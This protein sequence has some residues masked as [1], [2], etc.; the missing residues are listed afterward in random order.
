MNKKW[1]RSINPGRERNTKEFKEYKGIKH[2]RHLAIH[3]DE[4]FWHRSRYSCFAKALSLRRPSAQYSHSL[5]LTWQPDLSIY[6]T[7]FKL[8]S[9][10]YQSQFTFYNIFQEDHSLASL[11]VGPTTYIKKILRSYLNFR[12]SELFGRTADC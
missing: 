9:H 12:F 6:C 1:Q 8:F 5:T 11:R 7:F 2:K 4:T 3:N 10:L